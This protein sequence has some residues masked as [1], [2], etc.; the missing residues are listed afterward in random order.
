[1]IDEKVYKKV[2]PGEIVEIEIDIK[3]P[4]KGGEWGGC[5]KMK[6]D[7]GQWFG[8]PLCLLVMVE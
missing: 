1:V 7:N 2:D 4:T 3:T 8:T 5:W 6:G